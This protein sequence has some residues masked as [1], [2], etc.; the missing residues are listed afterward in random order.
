MLKELEKVLSSAGADT[1]EINLDQIATVFRPRGYTN[2]DNVITV[3]ENGKPTYYEVI[4]E[5]LYNAFKSLDQEQTPFYVKILSIPAQVL[6]AG[7][8]GLN[9]DFIG[10]NIARDTI[11]AGISSK[12]WFIPFVDSIKG[13]AHV[14]K[15]DEIFQSFLYSGGG[16]SELVSTDRNRMQ[17]YQRN[18]LQQSGELNVLNIVRH[19]IDFIRLLGEYSELATRVGVYKKAL[20][21]EGDS[22]SGR[23][24]AGV[25][26]RETTVDF[27]RMGTNVKNINKAIAFFNSALQGGDVLVRAAMRDKGKFA[28][29]A[30]MYITLPSILTYLLNRDD[31]EY[32]EIPQ[33]QKDTFWLFKI[34]GQ[35]W[36]IPKPFEMGMMFGSLVERFLAYTDKEDPHALDGWAEQLKDSAL[37]D[38]IPTALLPLIE[39]W[40]NHDMFRNMPIIPQ[41]DEYKKPA[42]QY[43]PYTSSLA[44]TLGKVFNY[45]PYKIDHLIKGYGAGVGQNISNIASKGLELTGIA[46]KKT[47]PDK[48][49]AQK[50]PIIRGL[51]VDPQR[52]SK[53][54]SDFYDRLNEMEDDYKQMRDSDG[55]ELNQYPKRKELRAMRKAQMEL[56]DLNREYKEVYA[57]NKMDAKTKREKLSKINLERINVARKALGKPKIRE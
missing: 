32:E 34:G 46:E 47:E 51:T 56:R 36:R 20:K 24:L 25:A 54:V 41:G 42:D 11:F 39:V 26:S 27:S 31:D 38:I 57:D 45:S 21:K 5:D 22:V 29:R 19:P 3:F 50:L 33:Y 12:Y 7:A 53:S 9:V 23:M 55:I 37:P 30:I 15:K 13:L 17:R 4:D 14:L 49:L 2:K 8:T 10:R 48:P 52:S 16:D 35:W 43:G 18:L 6:R 44:K 28:L 40:T 1:T